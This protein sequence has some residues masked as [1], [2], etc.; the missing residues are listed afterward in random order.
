MRATRLSREFRER[1]GHPA[2]VGPRLTAMVGLEHEFALWRGTDRLDFRT[3]V[4]EIGL[5]GRRLDP[6]D[7]N[8]YRCRW[9]GVITADGKEAELASPPVKRE[10]V[11]PTG[12]TVGP[13]T[14]GGRWSARSRT[15]SRSTVTPRISV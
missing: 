5:D 12:S 13:R 4:H 8:A 11:S 2:D 9:G 15:T 14:A 7:P 3:L 10:A 1:L 6:G